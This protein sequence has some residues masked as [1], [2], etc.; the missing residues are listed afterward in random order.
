M[1]P[2]VKQSFNELMNIVSKFKSPAYKEFF[3][4]KAI[5]NF[6]DVKNSINRKCKVS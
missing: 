2:I 4:R 1:L 6:N 5:E 3:K